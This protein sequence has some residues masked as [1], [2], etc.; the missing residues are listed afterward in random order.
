MFRYHYEQNQIG[1]KTLIG[2]LFTAKVFFIR[3]ASCFRK[4]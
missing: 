2:A 3:L 1:L 4:I